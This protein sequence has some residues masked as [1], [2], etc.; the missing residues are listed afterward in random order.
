MVNEFDYIGRWAE[1]LQPLQERELQVC[2]IGSAAGASAKAFLQ[3]LPLARITCIDIRF[4]D[5][6]DNNLGPLLNRVEKI[7]GRSV[8]A[9]DDMLTTGRRFDLIYVDGSHTRDDALLDSI[10]AWR[11][12]QQGGII[13][14]DDYVWG[15]GHLPVADRCKEAIDI[16]LQMH[17]EDLTILETGYQVVGR[18]SAPARVTNGI[19]EGFTYSRTLRNLLRFLTRRP[20]HRPHHGA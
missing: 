7:E 12:L 9:L 4:A 10:L 11:L 15:L 19:S 14:W 2:E 1:R 3:L 5:E 20:L 17:A 8:R 6:F 16:F 18:K 13:I